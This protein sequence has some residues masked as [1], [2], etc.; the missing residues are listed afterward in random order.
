MQSELA[1]LPQT[2]KV[3]WIGVEEFYPK[4]QRRDVDDRA[5]PPQVRWVVLDMAS[6]HAEGR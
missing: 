1:V 6:T 4:T 2:E 5:L 3:D